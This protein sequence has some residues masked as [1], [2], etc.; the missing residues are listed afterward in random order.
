MIVT[1]EEAIRGWSDRGEIVVVVDELVPR[2][3]AKHRIFRAGSCH[4]M[5][6]G[7][8]Q[9]HLDALHKLAARIGLKPAWFQPHRLA[10]HYDLTVGKR[11]RAVAAGAIEVPATVFIIELRR[12][13][14]S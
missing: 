12:I 5:A 11:A 4:L 3:T 1:I 8:S 14:S 9:Q 13:C 2:P 10:P 7:Y 6:N